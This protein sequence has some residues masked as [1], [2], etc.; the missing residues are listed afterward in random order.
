MN[1]MLLES[2]LVKA[3]QL[4]MGPAFPLDRFP[5]SGVP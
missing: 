4:R 2:L 1:N 5:P 3:D